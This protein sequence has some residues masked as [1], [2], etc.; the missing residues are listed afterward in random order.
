[1]LYLQIYWIYFNIVKFTVLGVPKISFSRRFNKKISPDF[2]NCNISYNEP[3]MLR[4]T[5]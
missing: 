5:F 2:P 3:H 4:E 1:M